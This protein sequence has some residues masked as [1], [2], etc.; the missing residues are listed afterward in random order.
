MNDSSERRNHIRHPGQ[1]LAA[2]I[3]GKSY[4]VVN[5]STGGVYFTAQGF[6]VGNPVKLVLRST[7]D[8][9]L[10]IGADCKVIEV[11]GDCVHAEFLRPTMPLMRFVIGQIGDAMGVEPHYFK[12]AANPDAA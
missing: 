7:N 12:K 3:S 2:E 5:I 6:F 11:E 10:F 8:E 1:N 9:A 4:P